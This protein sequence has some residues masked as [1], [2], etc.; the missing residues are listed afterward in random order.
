[1]K[2]SMDIATFA[3]HVPGVPLYPYQLEIVEPILESIEGA[4]GRIFTVMMARQAGK[5]Q[6]SAVLEAYLLATRDEGAITISPRP[7]YIAESRY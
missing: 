5:N 4:H 1:M 6:L 2:L 3:E 7:F